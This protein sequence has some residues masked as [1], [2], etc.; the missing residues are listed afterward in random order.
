[1]LYYTQKPSYRSYEGSPET[2]A[3]FFQVNPEANIQAQAEKLTSVLQLVT[4]QLRC[5]TWSAWPN[6]FQHMQAKA[7]ARPFPP[8]FFTLYQPLTSFTFYYFRFPRPVVGTGHQWLVLGIS[9]ATFVLCWLSL[10]LNKDLSIGRVWRTATSWTRIRPCFG[11][12][13]WLDVI[14]SG[15]VDLDENESGKL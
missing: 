7:C 1:M 13:T 10:V 5:S 11:G 2:V 8:E 12:D 14:S 9:S 4:L 3:V 15:V 6:Y